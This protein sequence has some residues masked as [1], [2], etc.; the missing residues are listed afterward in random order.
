MSD[1][2]IVLKFG[3]STVVEPRHWLTIASQ[4]KH[5]IELGYRPFLVLSAL[6]NVSNL[7]EGLIHQA[8][9]GVYQAPISR[10]KELHYQLA[11]N[12][13]LEGEQLL[14]FWFSKL[15][16]VCG[17][18]HRQGYIEPKQH[19]KVL[20]MGELLSSTLGAAYLNQQGIDTHWKDARQLLVSK[21]GSDTYH[22][23][24]DAQCYYEAESEPLW[25]HRL[26][27]ADDQHVI[28]TQGFIASDEQGETVLLGREGSDTSAAYFGALLAASRIEIWTD[29]PGVFTYN[30]NLLAEARQ[31]PH[32]G[33]QQARRL[34]KFGAKVL[35]PRAIAPA[36]YAA[37]PVLVRSTRHPK[38]KGSLISS[39]QRF[40]RDVIGLASET[41]LTRF[42]LQTLNEA[43]GARF[44]ELLTEQGYNLI[45]DAINAQGE[46]LMS[47]A[48]SDS[49]E[50]QK[51]QLMALLKY[52][53]EIQ[54][55]L[56]I[57]YKQALITV[58]GQQE[59]AWIDNLSRSLSKQ[60]TLNSQAQF[61]Y[62][63]LGR[64][65][66]LCTHQQC[67]LWAKYLHQQSIENNPEADD[68]GP[69]WKEIVQSVE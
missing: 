60:T 3:G 57:S 12:L 48:N 26:N 7:L 53:P 19:A 11:A 35:H 1:K 43:E 30:P 22:H 33:Y 14:T 4:I 38:L 36:E 55:S 59:G 45:L 56:N 42:Q 34:A 31:I 46:L 18:I 15:S 29:V 58:I 28:V 25:G 49:P 32:L 50:P 24:T 62:P 54:K 39:S 2:W 23:F 21:N 61:A 41:E 6:K 64:F 63:Q 69:S 66:L 8:V 16:A 9:S 47:Y 27:F 37:I 68:F 5:K 65:S 10:I 17:E 52:H 67:L 20:A 44:I 40:K 51:A 13:N